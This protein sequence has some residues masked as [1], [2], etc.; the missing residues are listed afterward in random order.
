MI[1]KNIQVIT[2]INIKIVNPIPISLVR[3]IHESSPKNS[4]GRAPMIGINPIIAESIQ[5]IT[6]TNFI[7]Y[8]SPLF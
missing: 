2:K 3:N 5:I 8:V 7:L 6:D 4:S 1:A